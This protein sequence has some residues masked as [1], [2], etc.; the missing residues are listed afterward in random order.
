VAFAIGA[1]MATTAFAR[2]PRFD[3]VV[4]VVMALGG[5]ASARAITAIWD[6]TIFA[7]GFD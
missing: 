1:F 6:T 3:H 5:A 7:N 4:V 2:V